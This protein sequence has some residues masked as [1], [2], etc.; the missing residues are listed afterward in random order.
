MQRLSDQ[1]LRHP[2]AVRLGSV[3]QSDTVL[4]RSTKRSNRPPPVSRLAE[5]PRLTDDAHRPVAK[6]PNDQIPAEHVR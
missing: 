3:D 5:V 6:P 2:R 1:L 4:D